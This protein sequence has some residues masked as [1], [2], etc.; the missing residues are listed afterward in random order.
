MTRSAILVTGVGIVLA[1]PL[2]WRALQ[3]RFDPFEPIVAFCAAWGAM[4][5]A[6]PA[7]T[8]IG[9]D[10]D[11]F[12][13]D[14]LETF[15]LVLLLALVGAVA[16]ICSYELSLG[17]RFARSLPSF[18][19]LNETR[20]GWVAL[21]VA[22]ASAV[23]LAVAVATTVGQDGLAVLL[24]GRG[25]G[26]GAVLS[27]S[28]D[29]L[30]NRCSP[31]PGGDRPRRRRAAATTADHCRA[32]G[33]SRGRRLFRTVPA[34][35]RIVLLP[36]LVASRWWHTYDAAPTK[37]RDTRRSRASSRSSCRSSWSSRATP[38]PERPWPTSP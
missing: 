21:G 18:P 31:C 36:F 13:I 8:L 33:P 7:A 27:G 35:N 12:G 9:G 15:P 22:A 25:H 16:F 37:G 4:F 34:G 14:V 3:R 24:E 2:L 1:L 29:Y 30:W 38:T 17:G 11:Y 19:T 5:V 20:A 28:S 26:L 6:R 32:R 10:T 23:A